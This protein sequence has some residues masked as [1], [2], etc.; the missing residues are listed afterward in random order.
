MGTF[1]GILAI[2]QGIVFVIMSFSP[3]GKSNVSPVINFLLGI[4]FMGIGTAMIG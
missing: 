2:I 4:F 3:R 1:F